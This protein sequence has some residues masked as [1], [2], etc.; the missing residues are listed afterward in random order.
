M[1]IFWR[2]HPF[3]EY[4]SIRSKMRY[5]FVLMSW[6]SF[7]NWFSSTVGIISSLDTKLTLK[8]SF[9]FETKISSILVHFLVLNC[10][11]FATKATCSI[12]RWTKDYKKLLWLFLILW[13]HTWGKPQNQIQKH[14]VLSTI[15]LRKKGILLVRILKFVWLKCLIIVP[16]YRLKC[17]II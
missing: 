7:S 8:K 4:G 2:N 15:C 6:A 1:T 11:Y 16:H 5:S 13:R 17:L 9:N 14:Y 3:L 10:F 12:S